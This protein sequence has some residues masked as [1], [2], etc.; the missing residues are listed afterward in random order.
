VIYF[1]TVMKPN[2]YPDRKP[3]S[4]HRRRTQRGFALVISLSLMVLLTVLSVGLLTLSSVSLRASGQSEAMQVARANARMALSLA[5]GQ[6]QK[7]TGPDQRITAPASLSK[8]GAPS[9]LTGVWNGKLPTASEP[10]PDKDGNFVGY[11][12]SGSESGS[13]NSQ[14]PD[15]TNG[16][17]LLGEGSLGKG[18]DPTS[19]VRATKVEN[20]SGGSGISGRY[21]WSVLDEGTKAKVD[22][23]RNKEDQFGNASHQAAVGAPARFGV[24]AIDKFDTFDWFEGTD[25]AKLYTIPTSQLIDKMPELKSHQY[26]VTTVARGLATDS[27]RGG[28]RKDLS[29]LFGGTTLPTDYSTKHVYDEATVENDI[30]NPF[31]SQVFEYANLYKTLSG[32]NPTMKAAVPAGYNPVKYDARSRTYKA[33]PVAPK[34]MIL[35]PIVAKVQMQFSMVSKDAH[36]PW[37]GG[38]DHN[39]ATAADNYMIYMIY[40]PIVTLYNPYNMPLSF[41]Q[42]RIDFKDL[43]IGFRFYRNGLAQT[44]T[45]AHMNQLFVSH[46]SSSA[47][48]KTFGIN[49]RSSFAG[50]SSPAVVM[51]PGENKV[52]GESVDGNASFGNGDNAAFFDYT[53]TKTANMNLAPGYP[54]QGVGFWVDWLTPQNIKTAADD[55]QGV[56]PLALSDSIDVG[57]GPMPSTVSGNR[58]S[59]E[60]NLVKGSQRLR[61]GIQR[62]TFPPGKHACSVLTWAARCISLRPTSSRIS[63]A[64]RPSP[65]SAS[66]PRPPRNPTI[67]PSPGSK[68]AKPPA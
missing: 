57:F 11:L 45:L 12:A 63:S 62:P 16:A 28:L 27:A 38:V 24:E 2:S 48:P 52:F 39:T 53:D 6:L 60:L 42:L 67:R 3:S 15:L 65:S 51:Q 41:D 9:W 32:T 21:A 46:D 37:A 35:M 18:H 31:W 58:L 26:D 40:S 68:E 1:T 34:G 30:P 14:L 43:P 19:Y 49:V 5:I 50:T 20:P 22:M 64:P 17:V 13:Q 23:V 36:G 10:T 8:S 66:T 61:S 4:L 56:F 25:Q 59:I 55:G 7:T 54:S 47:I 29:L 33:N 44:T